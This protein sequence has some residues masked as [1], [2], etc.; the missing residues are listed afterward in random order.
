MTA[1]ATAPAPTLTTAQK[2]KSIEIEIS[3]ELIERAEM[4]HAAIVAMMSRTN[5]IA[6]GLPG[7]GKSLLYDLLARRINGRYRRI[8]MDRQMDKSEFMGMFDLPN[9]EKTGEYSRNTTGTAIDA[10]VLVLEEVGKTGPA[11]TTPM[12]MLL[13]EH[14]AKPGTTEI[15]VDL[16]VAF[17]T[18][19]EELEAGQEA[20]GDRFPVKL[21][22]DYIKS[23]DGFMALLD[24][25][26]KPRRVDDPTFVT[27]DEIRDAVA[28][29][30]PAIK[31]PLGV[32]EELAGLRA[33]L[34]AESIYPSDRTW[35]LT[36]RMLQACAWLES[37]DTVL[38]DDIAFLRHVLWSKQ[39]ERK[40]VGQLVMAHT[41]PVAR[42]AI[43]LLTSVR[44]SEALLDDLATRGES[45]ETR[46]AAG[47]KIQGDINKMNRK[48]ADART[49]ATAKGRNTAQLD[50]VEQR[51]KEL[52][53]RVLTEC[54]NMPERGARSLV[55]GP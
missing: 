9:Y 12:L 39:E 3:Y 27:A 46:S 26:L 10:D 25:A 47:G 32:R 7:T 36:V 2:V 45:L 53:F 37:R 34:A 31:V 23:A 38:E 51:V 21:V 15:D 5:G 16:L 11:V 29:E 35:Y 52:H 18:S 50:E 28:N 54:L 22:F 14:K 55:F 4:V 19:N 13:N 44:E 48:L 24:S 1:L 8:L 20:F 41:G 43:T 6:Y 42:L 33:D 49:E 30:V 40:K 17:G